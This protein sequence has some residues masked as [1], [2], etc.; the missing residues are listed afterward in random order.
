MNATESAQIVATVTLHH[1]TG[2]VSEYEF[3]SAR[4]AASFAASAAERASVEKAVVVTAF[5][6]LTMTYAEG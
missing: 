4:R 3:R 1:V 2:T 6:A 5:G